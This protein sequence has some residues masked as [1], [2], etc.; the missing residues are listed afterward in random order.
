[1]SDYPTRTILVDDQ[2]VQI[3]KQ[4]LSVMVHQQ[5]MQIDVPDA[6]LIGPEQTVQLSNELEQDQWALIRETPQFLKF[7]TTLWGDGYE[8]PPKLARG[9][10]AARHVT[11]LILMMVKARAEGKTIHLQYPETY[12]HPAQCARFMSL[13]YAINPERTP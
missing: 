12:L 13:V 3:P 8:P 1:M 5:D 11:G 6:V 4:P 2:E 7:W 9:T 10:L